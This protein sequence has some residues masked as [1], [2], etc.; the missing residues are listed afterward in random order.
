MGQRL[1]QSLSGACLHGF[2][3]E[4]VQTLGRWADAAPSKQL[5]PCKWGTAQGRPRATG[6]SAVRGPWKGETVGSRTIP[7]MHGQG[8]GSDLGGSCGWCGGIQMPLQGALRLTGTSLGNCRVSARRTSQDC[9]EAAHLTCAACVCECC[10][11]LDRLIVC[12]DETGMRQVGAPV[13]GQVGGGRRAEEETCKV[14]TRMAK[15]I[16]GDD[17]C[18]R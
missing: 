15:V 16:L 8:A 11:R 3:W 1:G 13:E 9:R 14:G 5:S 18:R 17:G 4:E 10:T 2:A 6:K 12:Q 7:V